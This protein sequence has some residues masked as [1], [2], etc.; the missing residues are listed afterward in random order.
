MMTLHSINSKE[1]K[2][3]KKIMNRDSMLLIAT[4]CNALFFVWVY[5][6]HEFH[7]KWV[8]AGVFHEMFMI[9]MLLMAPILM[10]VATIFLF[11]KENWIKN[12]ISFLI[13]AI[14]TS[15]II[16]IIYQDMI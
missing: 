13:A 2:G 8:I 6:T 1:R 3:F 11:Q 14:V 7:I 16:W 10:I 9:P 4:I 12:L 5:A 15:I